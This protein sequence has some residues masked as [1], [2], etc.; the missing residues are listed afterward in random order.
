MAQVTLYLDEETVNRID[1]AAKEDGL[2]RS[3]WVLDLIQSRLVDRWPRSVERLAGAWS[4]LPTVDDLRD[5]LPADVP[6]ETL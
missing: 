3:R 5:E 1:R 2:S 6:R 4:D